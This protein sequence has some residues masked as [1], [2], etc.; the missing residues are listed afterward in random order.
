MC[1]NSC[2]GSRY[3]RLLYMKHYALHML[4]LNIIHCLSQVIASITFS[5]FKSKYTCPWKKYN[6]NWWKGKYERDI[7]W[8]VIICH[9]ENSQEGKQ[10]PSLIT[11]L[12]DVYCCGILYSWDTN[13]QEHFESLLH[14][15]YNDYNDNNDYNDILKW[16]HPWNCIFVHNDCLST[17]VDIVHW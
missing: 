17:S 12:V 4:Y 7:H 5:G 15:I 9:L 2:N 16:D 11:L 6:W 8:Q 13:V 1:I 10:T 3:Y 14:T